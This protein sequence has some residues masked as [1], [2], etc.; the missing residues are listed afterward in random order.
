MESQ[1]KENSTSS[2]QSSRSQTKANDKTTKT[3]PSTDLES[4]DIDKEILQIKEKEEKERHKI[5]P[6]EKEKAQNLSQLESENGSKEKD[7]LK[8]K[9]RDMKCLKNDSDTKSGDKELKKKEEQK[10]VIT[11]TK[12]VLEKEKDVKTEET[13]CKKLASP[14]SKET[15]KD[16]KKESLKKETGKKEMKKKALEIIKGQGKVTR[17][18][19]KPVSRV[20][21]ADTEIPIKKEAKQSVQCNPA[22][23]KS[24]KSQDLSS[25]PA[26]K[27]H[28]KQVR[29]GLTGKDVE[30][31][32]VKNKSN[33]K[34]SATI[35]KS[36][37][38]KVGKSSRKETKQ[39][40]VEMEQYENKV[41]VCK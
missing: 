3:S 11:E 28:Q 16:A 1:A 30:G 14:K 18:K 22:E 37:R 13:V 4:G 40:R 27:L 25:S 29:D 8:N 24:S 6:K 26:E 9:Q 32:E 41:Q 10:S 17:E 23:M 19:V 38:S 12:E 35:L 39:I 33:Q 2:G 21:K 34:K 15:L 36:K 20:K 31:T 7:S 5:K